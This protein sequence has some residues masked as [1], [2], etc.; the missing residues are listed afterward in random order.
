MAAQDQEL[1]ARLAA[2]IT[3]EMAVLRRLGARDGFRGL[4]GRSI[5]LTH[6]HVLTGLRLDGPTRIGQLAQRLG[7]SVASVTGIVSRMEERSLVR[8]VRDR[9][10]RRVVHVALT[11]EGERAIAEVEGRGREHLAHLLD[12]LSARQLEQLR[13]GLRALHRAAEEIEGSNNDR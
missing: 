3:D 1:R 5:S 12:R 10:D 11:A 2:E 6:L 4:L 9:A 8:R 7:I 13:A